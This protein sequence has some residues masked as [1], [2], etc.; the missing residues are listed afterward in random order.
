MAQ[1]LGCNKIALGHHKDDA[2]ETL[3]MNLIFQ[4]SI[5]TIPP[6]LQM[7]KMPIELIR[8][9]CLIEEAEIA[10]YAQLCGFEKQLKLCPL[11]KVS[12][13]AQIKELIKQLETLN[14][15]IRD[16]IWG[17]MENIKA[18]YLPNRVVKGQ[19]ERN[20]IF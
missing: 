3:M 17:A 14:P 11:E 8:P 13:R 6:L 1:E 9:L 20:P 5:S 16:S 2:V 12:S 15:N 18:G 4:G 10:R 7:E 19:G